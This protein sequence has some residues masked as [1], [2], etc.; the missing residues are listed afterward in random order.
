[1]IIMTGSTS[2][3]PA[4]TEHTESAF[5]EHT[6]SAFTEHT[7]ESAP[8]AAR[9]FMTATR[10]HLGY[11]PAGMAR[12]A[13]S[14]QLTDGFLKL[15]AIFENTTLEPAAREVVIMTVATRNRCH[16]CVAMHTARLTALGADP[17]V[18][19]A[20]RDAGPLPD[21]RLDAIRVFTLRVLDTTGDVG[22][23]ALRDFLARGYTSQNA[24]E[25]VLG[26]GT[27]TMS[28]LANRLTGAPVDDQLAAYAW[29]PTAA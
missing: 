24:L 22:D 7:I 15:S 23:Q 8:A 19:A 25:V 9:R 2:T 29:H 18:I 10:D 5:T 14:P 26:V 12:M 17:D 21:D 16:I 20:L 13:A 1:M 28:T 6:E 27:Y 3:E 11:L 4:F